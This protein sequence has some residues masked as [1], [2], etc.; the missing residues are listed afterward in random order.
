MPRVG[1]DP[2]P[3]SWMQAHDGIRRFL[4]TEKGPSSKGDRL[5]RAPLRCR[6]SGPEDK[7]CSLLCLASRLHY[8]RAMLLYLEDIQPASEVR[9]RV[10]HVVLD[11]PSVETQECG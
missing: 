3:L 5:I 8:P 9:G 2:F 4:A 11:Y 1:G 7:V 6:A 10:L